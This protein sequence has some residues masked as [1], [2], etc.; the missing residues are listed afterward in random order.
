MS[1][2]TDWISWNPSTGCTKISTGCKNCYAERMAR[3]LQAM[4]QPKYSDGFKLTIHEDIL[5]MPLKLKKSKHI[6]VN[7]MSDLFHKDMPLEFIQKVFDVMN[8][9]Y[10]HK[11][12]ILTKRDDILLKYSQSLNWSDNIWMGVSVENKD[13]SYRIDSLKKTDAKI[14]FIC[15]EP[16][17]GELNNLN[18]DGIDWAVLGGESGMGARPIKEEW[19]IDIK[20]QCGKNN[21]AFFFKQWGGK[22]KKESGNI[23]QGQKWEQFPDDIIE[24]KFDL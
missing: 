3:R 1:K 16:L 19:V 23:L 8:K 20:N 7:S 11:F 14:K 21:V 15:F 10:W 5:D 13:Y 22:N 12:Q 4:G 6:F 18:L 17:L 9:A 2:N 24:L